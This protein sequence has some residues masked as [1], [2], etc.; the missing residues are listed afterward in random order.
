MMDFVGCATQCL[1]DVDA[2]E[3]ISIECDRSIYKGACN[4]CFVSA[5]HSPMKPFIIP[6][7]A[8]RIYRRVIDMEKGKLTFL[9]IIDKN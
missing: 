1:K 4:V 2:C 5:V 9:Y 6:T 3:G 8:S 7:N